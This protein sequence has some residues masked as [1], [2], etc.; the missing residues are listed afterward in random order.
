MQIN[1]DLSTKEVVRVEKI[2]WDM[3]NG[4][5]RQEYHGKIVMDG[6][7][8]MYFSKNGKLGFTIAAGFEDT[9]SGEK[10]D[11]LDVWNRIV[12]Y[13]HPET[14]RDT[15]DAP[16]KDCPKQY[17]PAQPGALA[18]EELIAMKT[19]GYSTDELIRLRKEGVL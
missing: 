18:P 3:P 1:M 6:M 5:Y 7:Y 2:D 17:A 8:A 14:D 9:D 16:E 19:C 11:L 15:K 12:G 13:Q 4:L 10:L